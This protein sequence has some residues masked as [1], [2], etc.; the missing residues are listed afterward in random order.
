MQGWL[1]GGP[2]MTA[3]HSGSSSCICATTL[4][5]WTYAKL[6]FKCYWNTDLS[7]AFIDAQL[8]VNCCKNVIWKDDW[9][10]SFIGSGGTTVSQSWYQQEACQAFEDTCAVMWSRDHGLGLETEYVVLVSV[11]GPLVSIL[12]A[13]VSTLVLE[14]WSWSRSFDLGFQF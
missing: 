4:W 5:S 1:A 13:P 10:G 11:L 8:T 9:R 12:V 6:L 7:L 14:H 2:R 3:G